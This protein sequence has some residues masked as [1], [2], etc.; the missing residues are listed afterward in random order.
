MTTENG[1][2]LYPISSGYRPQFRYLGRNNDVS[3]TL[4][5]AESVSPGKCVTA[6]LTFFRPELQRNRLQIGAVFSLAEGARDVANGVVLEIH[7]PE[8]LSADIVQS[9]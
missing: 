9:E 2:R 8:M 3:I 6:D 5:D 7:D 1:G 4:H